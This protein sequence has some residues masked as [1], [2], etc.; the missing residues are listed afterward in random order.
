MGDGASTA[1]TLP[2]AQPVEGIELVVREVPGVVLPALGFNPPVQHP[3]VVSV[4]LGR[5]DSVRRDVCGDVVVV[6]PSQPFPGRPV[7]LL[8]K[9]SGLVMDPQ[10]LVEPARTVPDLLVNRAPHPRRR[11][12]APRRDHLDR[13]SA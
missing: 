13:H 11:H 10:A 3:G 6:L 2:G 7:E 1:D 5:Q 9:V 12:P 8:P 4:V